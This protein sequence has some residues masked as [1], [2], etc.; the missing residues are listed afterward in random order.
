MDV[1]FFPLEGVQVPG[2]KTETDIKNVIL[3]Y[4]DIFKKGKIFYLII[5]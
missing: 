2:W 5:E 3:F 4:I 1:L